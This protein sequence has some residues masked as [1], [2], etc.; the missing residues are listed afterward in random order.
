MGV[1]HY[2]FVQSIECT[3][4]VMK[5][6]A[7]YGLGVIRMCQCRVILGKMYHVVTDVD[8]MGDCAC[9]GQGVHGNLQLPF[10]FIVSQTALK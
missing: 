3:T 1:S 8:N 7:N 4:Q 2:T 5:P 6:K 10:H 9:V